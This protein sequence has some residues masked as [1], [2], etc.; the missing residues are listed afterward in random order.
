MTLEPNPV[1]DAISA[2]IARVRRRLL[3]EECQP[4]FS[5]DASD[6]IIKHAKEAVTEL[7]EIRAK[8]EVLYTKVE[9]LI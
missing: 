3:Q 6:D 1:I 4:N 2:Q 8:L 9:V 5:A 7:T